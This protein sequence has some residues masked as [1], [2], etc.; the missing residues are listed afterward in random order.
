MAVDQGSRIR[1][2]GSRAGTR[3]VV[4]TTRWLK[5]RFNDF[6]RLLTEQPQSLY[7]A[8]FM[9]IGYGLLFFVFL[10]REFPHRHE[11]W[12]PDSP[13]TP[14]LARQN[15]DQTGW[16]SFFILSDNRQYFEACYVVS[17]L[18]AFL[19]MVGWRTRA[20]SIVF[21]IV[22]TSFA[23]R[24]Q[25]VQDGGDNLLLL[26]AIYL[27]FT[28]CG[29]RWSV[30]AYLTRQRAQ[31]GRVYAPRAVGTDV[32]GLLAYF[33]AARQSAAIILHNCAMLA[34]MAQMCIVYGA[35]GLYKVQGDMWGNGTA[36]H[37]VLDSDLFR[38]W[39]AFSGFVD[40]HSLMITFASYLTV[41][42]QIAFPF[43]LFS[44]MKY[45]I[46]IILVGMHL[47]IAILLGMPGFSGAM[48]VGDAA[49]LPDRF[50]RFVAQRCGRAVRAHRRRSRPRRGR[51]SAGVVSER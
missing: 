16:F 31:T 43:S 21:A 19:F 39:P 1:P 32:T 25:L 20:M 45:A 28:A 51:L 18:A 26:M 35:A 47:G 22:V 33:D 27:S 46:L 23:G 50:Y 11:L 40:S 36:L 7:A 38:P 13:W 2:A 42:V 34:I 30:D 6:Y 5:I 4:T 17:L 41:L 44:K 15:Y 3:S 8:A 12:G 49:F 9:R 48:I 14:T 29:R 37:Y 10:V 24:N